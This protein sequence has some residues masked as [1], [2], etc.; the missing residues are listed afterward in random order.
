M[1][2]RV[3]CEGVTKGNGKPPFP[4]RCLRPATRVIAG[5]YFCEAHAKAEIARAWAASR[6]LIKEDEP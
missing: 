6:P 3:R 2:K 1:T 4:Y 5:E